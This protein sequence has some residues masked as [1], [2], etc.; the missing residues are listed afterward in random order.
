MDP[1]GFALENFDAV[2]RWRT[3][4]LGKTVDVSS[5]LFDGT[6]IDGAVELRGSMLRRSDVFVS[7]L[8]EKLLIYALGRGLTAQDMPA[9]R[10][11]HRKAAKQNYRFSALILGVVESLPFQMTVRRSPDGAPSSLAASR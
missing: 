5:E 1:L 4:D 6:R 2:G 3:R 7:T 10:A 9:V 11:I 8:S